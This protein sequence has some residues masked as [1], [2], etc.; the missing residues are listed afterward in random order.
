MA[1]A[2]VGT[3]IAACTGNANET[4]TTGST[5]NTAGEAPTTVP[6]AGNGSHAENITFLAAHLPADARGLAAVDLTA[7]D[8][9]TEMLDDDGIDPMVGDVFAALGDRAAAIDT[10][11]VMTTALLA[12]TTDAAD[13]Q[14]LLARVR[15]DTL[16]D[17]LAGSPLTPA[18]TYGNDHALFTDDAGNHLVLLPE[19][20]LVA[21][22][23]AAIESVL[24]VVD[25]AP[26][27]A[28]AI[29]PFVDALTTGTMAT[30]AE[31]SYAYGLPGLFSDAGADRSLRGAAV[32]TGAFDIEAD[33]VS[34]EL[35]FHTANA[36]EFGDAYNALDRHAQQADPPLTQ[37]LTVGA[38]L[39]GDLGRV[40]VALP[41]TPL[42]PSADELFAS[43]NMFKK[44]FV[45]MEAYDYAEDVYNPGN[46]AWFDFLVKSELDDT[47]PAAG[48]VYIRWEFRDQAAVEAFEANELPEGFRLAPTRFLES[49]PEEGGYFLALNLYNGG[50]GMIVGGARAEWDVF[51]HGPD[52]ADPNAGERPRFMVVDV[53]AEEVSANAGDLLTPAEPVSHQLADGVVTSTVRRLGDDAPS[54]QSWFPVPDP[55]RNEVARFTREMAIGN[56]YIYWDHG[57]SDRVLYNA[58]TF[59]HDAYLVDPTQVTFTDNTRWAQYL[60]PVVADAVYYVNS[61]EY[62]ASPMANLDSEH[63]DI[64]PEWQAELLG[65]VNNGHQVGLMRKAVEL[66]FRGQADAL[67]EFFVSNDTPSAYYHFEITDPAGMEAALPLPPGHRLAPVQLLEGGPEAH[68]LTLSIFE[69]DGAMEGTRAEW[70]VYTDDGD[71]R[72]NM[73][74]IDLLT[75]EAA[76]DAVSIV[77][78]PSVVRHE[79]TDGSVNTSLSSADGLQFQ[80]SIPTDGATTEELSL[81][82][83]EAGDI[84]CRTNGVC[85]KFFYDAET[86][87]VPVNIPTSVTVE[88]FDTP[89]N[90]FVDA[91][92][93]SVFTRDNA[94]QYVVKRW[95]NLAIA[96]SELPFTGLENRTHAITGSGSL[97]G[98]TGDIADSTYTYTG[99]VVLE[100]D[101]LV[102][103]LDQQVDNALGVGHIYTTGTF[104][105]ATGTGT[106]TVVDCQGP[107]LL[108]S[109]IEIGSTEFYTAQSL[110]VSDP[111][112]VT[113]RVDVVIDL[114]GT[115][116]IADSSSEFTASRAD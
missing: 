48:S 92:P 95:E 41:P 74:I 93:S 115:F 25:G 113:W 81:D 8:S 34:G 100:A 16:G 52:G 35:V 67:L 97:V 101:R 33:T 28:S 5:A 73:M 56:D 17:L 12:H 90:D 27:G 85:D 36:T 50:G 4:A 10:A 47:P 88:V 3:L 9:P 19:G 79:L 15:G 62:V 91:T 106:Q 7:L 26:A 86:L 77:N 13:G 24:D 23:Q 37:P 83:I 2:V 43:R 94:Q 42:R 65:F 29:A 61:L 105:L 75:A 82:W 71:G 30:D 18:G 96:V 40:M 57:V 87:D 78:L 49:D 44:L 66:L 68:Y 59:N 54:F 80:A 103:S 55:A 102:F 116:G 14:F 20:V 69:V 98:R 108:C 1:L 111:D 104:D 89:W 99:D 46:P 6:A 58:S 11:R 107:A 39:V 45:G 114:G 112:V 31:L 21:G 72:P 38:P 51:V 60:K 70:S 63:L 76:F 84:V 53:A 64:T 32:I 22:T 109:G 110:D